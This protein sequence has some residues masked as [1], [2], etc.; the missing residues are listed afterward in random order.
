MR[1][2]FHWQMLELIT[3]GMILLAVIGSLTA[4]FIVNKRVSALVFDQA[5]QITSHFAHQSILPL[6]SDVGENAIYDLEATLSYS[7]VKCSRG[8]N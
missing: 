3:V 7:N 2:S 8:F 6:L 1:Q 5:A 4:A